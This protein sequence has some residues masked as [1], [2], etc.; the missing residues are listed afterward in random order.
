MRAAFYR[1]T[2]PGIKGIY[3]RGVRAWCSGDY[4]HCELVFSDGLSASSSW[5]DGGVRFKEIGYSSDN[6]DFVELPDFLEPAA[7]QWFI[8]HAGQPYDLLGNVGFIWRPIR[9]MDG[10]SFCSEALL[11][12]LG[13]KEPWR[14]DPCDAYSICCA[15]RGLYEMQQPIVNSQ[16]GIFFATMATQEGAKEPPPTREEAMP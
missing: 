12:A 2:R 5:E 1:G 13:V 16:D 14:F 9:G 6:W 15:L 4:S 11:A 10:A 7:R 3:N 8:D